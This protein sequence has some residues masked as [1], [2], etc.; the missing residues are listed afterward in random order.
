MYVPPCSTTYKSLNPSTFHQQ[1]WGDGRRLLDEFGFCAPLAFISSDIGAAEGFRTRRTVRFFGNETLQ[2]ASFFSFLYTKNRA[3]D[4]YSCGAPPPGIRGGG[5]ALLV[6]LRLLILR[7]K[8]G[9]CPL[10]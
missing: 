10:K 3:P 9:R 2:G 6:F 8:K 1:V 7:I 4:G 5:S